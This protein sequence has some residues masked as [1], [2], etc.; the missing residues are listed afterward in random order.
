MSVKP[1][2]V[3]FTEVVPSVANLRE[4]WSAKA[5]RAKR[6][7]RRAWLELRALGHGCEFV[8][9][10]V[11]TLTRISPRALDG[12]N[13]QSAFKASRDGVADWLGTDDADSRVTWAY[14]QERAKTQAVRI[15]VSPV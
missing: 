12:D 15:E 2:T 9:P 6:H 5:K 4:H 1:L 14:A 8:G 10:L 3:T 7:R 13:L 11:V